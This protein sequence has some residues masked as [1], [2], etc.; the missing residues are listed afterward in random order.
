MKTTFMLSFLLTSAAYGA[1]NAPAA[2]SIG[3]TAAAVQIYF[4]ESGCPFIEPR[5]HTKVK[6]GTTISAPITEDLVMQVIPSG[7]PFIQDLVWFVPKSDM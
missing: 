6:P 7:C 4:E 2:P 5:S 1:D 3:R